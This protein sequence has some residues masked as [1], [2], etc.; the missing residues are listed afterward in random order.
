MATEFDQQPGI[1][2][3]NNGV[4]DFASGVFREHRPAD[5]ATYKTPCDFNPDADC[6]RWNRF[7]DFFLQGD[8]SLMDYLA[9]ATGY[10]LTGYVDKDILFFLYGKGANGKSTFTSALKMLTGDLMT[11]VPIEALMAKASDNN[12]DY[13]KAQMEGKRIVVSEC[14]HYGCCGL[15]A[16]HTFRVFKLACAFCRAVLSLQLR[17]H[18][19]VA[20]HMKAVMQPS[21]APAA[22]AAAHAA[23]TQ[24][25]RRASKPQEVKACAKSVL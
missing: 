25:Q 9:R 8:Q 5:R 18:V 13:R 17:G 16:P 21:L 4:L 7:L 10:S 11:T 14:A 23:E 20:V 2:V 12:F 24:R 19:C 15:P 6:P 1:L 22:A 3:V